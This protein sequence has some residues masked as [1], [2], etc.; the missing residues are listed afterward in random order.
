REQRPSTHT[1]AEEDEGVGGGG[2]ASRTSPRLGDDDAPA[3]L[4]GGP[5]PAQ[6]TPPPMALASRF[7]LNLSQLAEGSEPR[8]RTGKA[9]RLWLSRLSNKSGQTERD[10]RSQRRVAPVSRE[11]K[12][13]KG[14]WTG[15][16]RGGRGGRATPVG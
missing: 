3:A 10:G 11:G 16:E 4:G 8:R 14:G 9:G 2:H 1:R 15:G 6:K 12:C 13:L 7:G 5:P